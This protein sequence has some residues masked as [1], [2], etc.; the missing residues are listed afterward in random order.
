M[1]GMEQLLAPLKMTLTGKMRADPVKQEVEKQ[2][3][4]KRAAL[5]VV[6]ALMKLPDAG[7]SVM[8]D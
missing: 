8:C 4:L 7:E 5:R 1:T 3:E 6:V 2:S